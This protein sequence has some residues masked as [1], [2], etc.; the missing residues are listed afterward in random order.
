VPVTITPAAD[1][2]YTLT[3]NDTIGTVQVS[4][5]VR[6]VAAPVITSLTAGR[7]SSP[8]ARARPCSRS[9]PAAPAPSTRH[10]PGDSGVPV[11]TGNLAA[12]TT[13]T[14]TVSNEAG[15]RSPPP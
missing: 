3:Y 6:V 11:P 14:L 1:T 12:D 5:T 9:S 7:P 2:T 8:P 10:R 13:F 15:L 4:L